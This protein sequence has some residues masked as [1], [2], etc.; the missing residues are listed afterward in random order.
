MAVQTSTPWTSSNPDLFESTSHTSP[1]T[2]LDHLTKD[3]LSTSQKYQYDQAHVLLFMWRE[4]DLEVL[5]EVRELKH[6]FKTVYNFKTHLCIIPSRQPYQH[7]EAEISQLH[8]SLNSLSNLVIVYY[9]GHGHLLKYG[10]MTWSAYESVYPLYEGHNNEE[11]LTHE[12]EGAGEIHTNQS[13]DS[14]GLLYN[15]SS[16]AVLQMSLSSSTAVKPAAL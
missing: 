10:N 8:E 5:D 15:H 1:T 12:R 11:G 7:V 2:S 13:L 14:D 4:D 9:S 16:S 3:R 6:V